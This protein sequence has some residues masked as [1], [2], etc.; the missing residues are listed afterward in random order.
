MNEKCW[1][2]I[3]CRSAGW[4]QWN[5]QFRAGRRRVKLS[6]EACQSADVSVDLSIHYQ[7]APLIQCD[8]QGSLDTSA[9]HH[10][11]NIQRQTCTLFTPMVSYMNLT[12]MSLDC[13]GES[14]CQERNHKGRE[15]TNLIKSK[16]NRWGALY[17][18][19]FDDDVELVEVV[20]G[21]DDVKSWNV[22][23]WES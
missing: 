8:L 15:H 2:Y 21:S 14:G 1:G 4:Q 20:K 19:L 23:Y 10:R 7:T 3:K 5:W 9:E 22:C 6:V 12:S 11:A 13:G 16:H 18:K 17:R